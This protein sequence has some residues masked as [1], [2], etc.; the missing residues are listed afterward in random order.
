MK[1]YSPKQLQPPPTSIPTLT[2]HPHQMVDSSVAL[3][4]TG[5]ERQDSEVSGD[6][7]HHFY[8]MVVS[9]SYGTVGIIWSY[10]TL[11][12]F[13]LGWYMGGHYLE[14]PSYY[15]SKQILSLT[16]PT[17]TKLDPQDLHLVEDSDEEE[18]AGE[19]RSW[20]RR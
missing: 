2:S 20:R 8:S 10:H 6:A 11:I 17:L 12:Y 13:F 9:E 18:D 16:T 7:H 14:S 1:W 4:S 15:C 3:A 19:D 5:L